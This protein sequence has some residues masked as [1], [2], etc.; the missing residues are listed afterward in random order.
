MF[1]FIFPSAGIFQ[2]R[3]WLRIRFRISSHVILRS[4]SN[5]AVV[6]M[7]IAY[8]I[9]GNGKNREIDFKLNV[10]KTRTKVEIPSIISDGGEL[11]KPAAS[12]DAASRN[13]TRKDGYPAVTIPACL[14][15]NFCA[16]CGVTRGNR[17]RATR[18]NVSCRCFVR[19]DGLIF[20]SQRS[21][22]KLK[23]KHRAARVTCARVFL[24]PP[25]KNGN[26]P[27]TRWII[28]SLSSRNSNLW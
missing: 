12:F 20:I 25:K 2:L 7:N 16:A 9:A 8:L 22:V 13:C 24:S 4:Y 27:M 21:P 1:I 15:N 11:K 18:S 23:K 6:Q 19:T 14:V 26:E 5:Y 28:P 3:V 17:N 10:L